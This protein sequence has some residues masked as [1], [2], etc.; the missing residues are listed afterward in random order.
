MQKFFLAVMH[1]FNEGVPSKECVDLINHFITLRGE[2]KD[3]LIVRTEESLWS[4]STITSRLSSLASEEVF[5]VNMGAYLHFFK[6][7][8]MLKKALSTKAKISE[9]FKIGVVFK[10]D[11]SEI[12]EDFV[13]TVNLSP[14]KDVILKEFEMSIHLASE[15]PFGIHSMYMED[16]QLEASNTA[17]Q[18][19]T[20]RTFA[21]RLGSSAF[22]KPENFLFTGN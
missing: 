6:A 22:L 1:S 20:Y 3:H 19:Q 12:L 17:E 5:K 4:S 21:I 18:I 14:D 8:L 16:D 2:I 13:T 10:T 15:N 11:N 9:N 7:E